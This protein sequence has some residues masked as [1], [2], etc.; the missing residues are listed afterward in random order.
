MTLNSKMYFFFKTMSDRDMDFSEMTKGN[1]HQ[2]QVL[3]TPLAKWYKFRTSFNIGTGS[4]ELMRY[5]L[6]SELND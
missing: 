5:K 4:A 1:C 3:V 2:Y 6:V